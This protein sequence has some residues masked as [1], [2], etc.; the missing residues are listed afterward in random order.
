MNSSGAKIGSAL[1]GLCSAVAFFGTIYWLLGWAGILIILYV[2]AFSV[3]FKITFMPAGFDSIHVPSFGFAAFL[4]LWAVFGIAILVGIG[5][6][7]IVH[8]LDFANQRAVV[9]AGKT[10][11][12]FMSSTNGMI[13][14]SV[15]S[16]CAL[17]G[18]WGLHCIK[19]N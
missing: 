11:L 15:I 10:I 9:D 7:D 8:D 17:L 19:G 18:V 4:V 16:L 6:Y 5:C 13:T 1:F 12:N 2:L 14:M 3:H